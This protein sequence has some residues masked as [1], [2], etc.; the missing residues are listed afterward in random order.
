MKTAIRHPAPRPLRLPG[1]WAGGVACGGCVGGGCTTGC[2]GGGGV[3]GWGGGAGR[4]SPIGAANGDGVSGGPGSRVPQCWQKA[5]A[6]GSCPQE[7]HTRCTHF[8]LATA[9]DRDKGAHQIGGGAGGEWTSGSQLA[10]PPW[11]PGRPASQGDP[12]PVTTPLRRRR[13][14]RNLVTTRGDRRSAI[15]VRYGPRSR[16]GGPRRRSCLCETVYRP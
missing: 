6:P 3:A 2:M 12:E 10:F 7:P 15:T 16:S 9:S 5:P 4:S 1:A 13:P 14:R 11:L 8:T